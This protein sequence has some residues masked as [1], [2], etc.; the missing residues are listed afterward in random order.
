VLVLYRAST[1]FAHP[2]LPG[3][4]AEGPGIDSRFDVQVRQSLPFMSF[5]GAELE[6]LVAVRNFFKSVDADQSML[7]EL[8]VIN[9]PKQIVGG[10]TLH[11]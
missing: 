7:D 6:M 1:G 5:Y 10:V 4:D 2:A 9:P 3:T 8:L 11:F